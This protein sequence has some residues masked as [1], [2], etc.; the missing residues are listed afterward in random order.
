ME[1][2]TDPPAGLGAGLPPEPPPQPVFAIAGNRLRLLDTGPRRLDALLDLIAQART[3]LRL[4][5]YIYSDDAVGVRVRDAMIA[6]VARGV[7]VTLIVDGLGSDPAYTRDFF[8]PLRAAGGK[9]CFFV[10]RWG[11]RYLLRNHQKIALADGETAAARIIVG[12]FN[13]QDD[14]F[15]APGSDGW[16]DLGL[17]VEGEAAARLTGYFDALWRW[18][19]RPEMFAG[20][21][22][23]S[24]MTFGTTTSARS[25]YCW[26]SRWRTAP[27]HRR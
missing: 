23:Q 16:R 20:V 18:T 27:L 3:S 2:R 19:L 26:T 9:V 14:Y 1:Q 24:T 10:P 21:F 17:L 15:G 7:D 12:G 8:A 6:A 25:P 22:R 4:L 13:I 5:Y 11:R